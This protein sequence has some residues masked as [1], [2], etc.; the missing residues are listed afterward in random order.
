MLQQKLTGIIFGLQFAIYLQDRAISRGNLRSQLGLLKVDT[1]CVQKTLSWTLYNK[2]V[3][4]KDVTRC[5]QTLYKVIDR[6]LCAC[7]TYCTVLRSCDPTLLLISACRSAT[8]VNYRVLSL[9]SFHITAVIKIILPVTQE[10]SSADICF[11]KSI[12]CRE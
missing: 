10:A 6:N 3:A 11:G 2:H 8:F 9:I 7:R 4:T 5:L 1:I 12:N